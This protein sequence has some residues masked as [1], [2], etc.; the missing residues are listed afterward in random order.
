MHEIELAER[1]VER[2]PSAERVRFTNSGTEAVMV[3]LHLARAATGRTGVVKFEGAYHGGYDPVAVSVTPDGRAAGAY[4]RPTV[5]LEGT[6]IARPAAAD[7]HVLPWNDAPALERFLTAHGGSIG[8]IL[9]EP[10]ANKQ[11]V[12]TPEPGYL[13]AVRAL[14]DAHGAVLVFDEVI[15]FRASRGGAQERYGVVPD[16]TTLGKVIG[17]GLPVGAVAGR[18]SV[19]AHAKRGAPDG[20][21]HMGTFNAN[22]MTMAAGIAT[23]DLLTV[24]AYE[25]LEA[26]GDRVR[27]RLTDAI[28][29]AG[30]P[31]QVTGVGS[32]FKVHLHDRPLRNYRDTL[33]RPK[34][35]ELELVT[36][37]ALAGHVLPYNA[38]GAATLPMSDADADTLA[39]AVH[40]SAL[41]MRRAGRAGA[42]SGSPMAESA[43]G[44]VP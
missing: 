36:R 13:E 8:A 4:E 17:G 24:A 37:L 27:S 32:M 7:T 40:E 18:W 11:G 6:G 33:P 9:V 42:A 43:A 1:I 21:V 2:V 19:M 31:W 14:A 34:A 28:A 44:V 25:R 12:L 5:T 3:A 15:S 41:A 22:P 30:V 16:L 23:L 10:I 20:V 29:A 38:A 35:A 26:L 39:E